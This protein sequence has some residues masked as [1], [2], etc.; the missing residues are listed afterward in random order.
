MHKGASEKGRSE[1]ACTSV[2]RK[3]TRERRNGKYER[4]PQMVAGGS[5]ARAQRNKNNKESTL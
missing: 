2:T 5:R 3:L 4:G 1:A